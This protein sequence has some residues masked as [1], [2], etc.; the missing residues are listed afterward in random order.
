MSLNVSGTKYVRVY[1]TEIK[2]Q[3]SDKIVFEVC[4]VAEGVDGEANEESGN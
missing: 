1:D 3:A 2:L 4:D